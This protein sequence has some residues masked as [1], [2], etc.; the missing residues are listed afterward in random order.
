MNYKDCQ[1]WKKVGFPLSTTSNEAAKM[2][3]AV[4]TQYMSGYSDDSV[5]DIGT[6][7]QKMFMADPEFVLGHAVK[8]GLMLL[9]G[10]TSV[11]T[12]M[13]LQNDIDKMVTMAQKA[14]ITPLEKLH[15][16]AVKLYSVGQSALASD[17]WEEI[18]LYYP[19]DVLAVQNAFIAHLFSG[20]SYQMRD[21]FAR[22]LPH[23]EV[24]PPSTLKSNIRSLYAF[25]LEESNF[26]DEAEKL[27]KEVLEVS[28]K[29]GQATHTIAH[30]MEMMNRCEE[31]VTFSQSKERDFQNHFLSGHIYWHWGLFH[32]ERGEYEV[33][34]TLYDEQ[35][36]DREKIID[37]IDASS[38]LYRLELEGVNVGD[39]WKAVHK[40]WSPRIGDHA[41]MF[42][43]IH[44]FMAT[45]GAEQDGVAANFIESLRDFVNNADDRNDNAR[46]SKEVGL[47]LCEAFKAY[48]NGDYGTAVDI[49]T[50]IRYRIQEIGGSHA[51]RDIFNLF[52]I[53]AALKSSE[54]KHQ[55]LARS[56]LQERQ[57][58]RKCSPMTDR[59]LAQ[60][61]DISNN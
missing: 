56:L 18:L 59:I 60:L 23:W 10:G 17:K 44:S 36:M 12:N 58:R 57:A 7:L 39:R 53:H 43:D 46:V 24:L 61:G 50:P 5:G 25:G 27:A 31:G 20:R 15:V 11:R 2:Y 30:V 45:Q 33:A 22:V 37:L 40:R 38:F 42:D 48:G 28:P 6:C 9:A 35:L 1:E 52:L 55:L 47:P 13:D 21:C 32:I 49:M 4:V 14:D 19:T 29:D 16:E 34:L 51:Q 3:D 8:N 54:Q 26:Y 41:V